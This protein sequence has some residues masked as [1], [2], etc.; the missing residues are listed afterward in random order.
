MD[1]DRR[2]GHD[3]EFTELLAIALLEDLGPPGERF[4]QF[5]PV[6]GNPE[7]VERLQRAFD[8]WKSQL[9]PSISRGRRQRRT[10][11]TPG[12]EASKKRNGAIR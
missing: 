1:G 3:L 11:G 7:V 8:A 4:E 6:L 10:V 5:G 2:V 12:L 9:A